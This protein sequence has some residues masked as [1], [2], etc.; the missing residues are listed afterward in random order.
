MPDD[1]KKKPEET[2]KLVIEIDG[3]SK[4][5]TPDDVTNLVKQQASA[6]Q[7]T[8][9]VASVLQACDKY[10]VDPDTYLNQAEGAFSVVTNLINEGIIDNEGKLVKKEPDPK[11]KVEPPPD[12]PLKVGADAATA[13]ALEAIASKI[14]TIGSRIEKVEEGH[15]SLLQISIEN[16][17]KGKH[18][19][20][21]SEDV[22]RVLGTAAADPTKDL[23]QHADTY[24]K[25]KTANESALEK[26]YAEKFGIDLEKFNA[27]NQQD[28]RAASAVIE[29]KK[30]SFDPRKKDAISPKQAM[31]EFIARQG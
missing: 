22:S 18:P 26:K 9:A 27:L 28:G 2:P 23:W 24:S 31:K 19:D 7:K 25:A 16:Q 8:Q 3:E 10:G 17:I 14:D 20:F 4:E 30:I 15:S 12:T 21:T 11:P 1:P 6:T 5:F 13:K 29:G